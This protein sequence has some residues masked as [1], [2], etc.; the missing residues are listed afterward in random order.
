M[1]IC[2]CPCVFTTQTIGRHAHSYL[3]SNPLVYFDIALGRYGDATPLGTIVMEV[4]FPNA[5]AAK[6]APNTHD[7]VSRVF[8]HRAGYIDAVRGLVGSVQAC[9]Q[10]LLVTACVRHRS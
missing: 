10:K 1:S 2:V 8:N 7:D 5:H 9:L 4:K 6:R 3:Q